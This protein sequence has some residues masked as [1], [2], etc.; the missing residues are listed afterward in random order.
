LETDREYT[1]GIF[2]EPET[3][4]GKLELIIK[5]CWTRIKD[6]MKDTGCLIARFP[7]EEDREKFSAYLAWQ[8]GRK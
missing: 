1:L 7:S 2:P 6:G 4:V 8:A 5:P 3:A